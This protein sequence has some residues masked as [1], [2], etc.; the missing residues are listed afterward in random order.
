MNSIWF[1]AESDTGKLFVM[2]V[3]H[4]RMFRMILHT[5]LSEDMLWNNVEVQRIQ[6]NQ[7]EKIDGLWSCSLS[8]QRKLLLCA[9]LLEKVLDP[10]QKRSQFAALVKLELNSIW[11]IAE[12]DPRK[13]FVMIV[14]YW[15]NV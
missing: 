4:S 1:I 5:P 11:S 8:H 3:E 13:Q 6:V 7:L 2:I 9:I 14:Q 15:K 12:S 10:I